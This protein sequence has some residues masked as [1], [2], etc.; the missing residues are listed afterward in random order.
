MLIPFEDYIGRANAAKT[1]EEL[2]SVFLDTVGRHGY[3]RMTFCLLSDHAHI[4]LKAGAHHLRNYP[5]DWM[6]Y[7][8]SKDYASIDPVIRHVY[9]SPQ[10]FAWKDISQKLEMTPEQE[11]ILNMGAEAGLNNGLCAPVRIGN[12]FAGFGLASTEKVDACDPNYDLLTAY[13]NHFYLA[14]QRLHHADAKPY[15][16][17]ILTVKEREVLLWT[18]RGKSDGDIG[19]IMGI[20]DNTVKFHLRNIFEKLEANSRTL[21]VTKAI[22]L[23]LITP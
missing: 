23:G 11:G 12:G 2:V 17:V 3:D 16:N 9:Q 19:D 22:S 20:S 15:S 14:F 18:A 10:T 5:Q 1:D 7:Y 8:A 21:A 6:A 4:G 13:C